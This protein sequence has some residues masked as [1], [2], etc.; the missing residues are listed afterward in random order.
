MFNTFKMKKEK[1]LN[2]PLESENPIDYDI[3]LNT[4]FY[5]AKYGDEINL[6]VENTDTY[7][8]GSILAL[9]RKLDLDGIKVRISQWADWTINI[10]L[11]HGDK[12]L[13]VAETEIPNERI[14]W[15]SDSNFVSIYS[16]L[17][18]L[19]KGSWCKGIHNRFNELKCQIDQK[20]S[21]TEQVKSKEQEKEKKLAEEG[22]KQKRV[23]FE[24][25]YKK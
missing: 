12:E 11:Y 9:G 3:D 5:V 10:T 1:K 2:K 16:K 13:K 18:W 21:K 19:E 15:N 4:I 20:K 24:N 25:I 6:K 7:E 14:N 8:D 17:K 23:Y 22:N